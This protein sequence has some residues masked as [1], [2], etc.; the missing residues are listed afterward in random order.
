MRDSAASRGEDD[1]CCGLGMDMLKLWLARHGEAV[2]PDEAKSD[3]DRVLTDSGRRRLSEVT[4]WLLEREEPPELI[5]HSP[6]IRAKQTAEAIAS[7]RM[8]C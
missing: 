7:T 3:F 8:N 2:D 1:V 4:R 6:L 5:L